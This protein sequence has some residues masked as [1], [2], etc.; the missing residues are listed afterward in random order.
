M[1]TDLYIGDYI[2][3][4]HRDF[5]YNRPESHYVRI[6]GG[7]HYEKKARHDIVKR[8]R[9]GVSYFTIYPTKKLLRDDRYFNPDGVF[10]DIYEYKISKNPLGV[11][12]RLLES[13]TL[14]C[15]AT[16]LHYVVDG[17]VYMAVSEE[18]AAFL[19]EEVKWHKINSR[20]KVALIL[21]KHL[22]TI[23]KSRASQILGVIVSTDS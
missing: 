3:R 2:P 23:S 8:N 21:C 12:V 7:Y 10:V 6:T 22:M 20:I 15:G 19:G 4:R 14:E 11:Y 5:L 9:R 17:I 1:E 18:G 13:Y 16:P